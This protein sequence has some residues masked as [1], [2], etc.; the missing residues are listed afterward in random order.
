MKFEY[1]YE[2]TKWPAPN[3]IVAKGGHMEGLN[4][5]NSYPKVFDYFNKPVIVNNLYF[6]TTV[7]S[8]CNRTKMR[9]SVQVL[10]NAFLFM[11]FA[12]ERN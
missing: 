8:R 9:S 2:N 3:V 10:L 4:I 6:C 1:L 5:T 7:E 12:I 11:Q